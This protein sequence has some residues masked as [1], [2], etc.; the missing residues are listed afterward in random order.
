VVCGSF[1]KVQEQMLSL[2]FSSGGCNN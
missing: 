1:F 2:F